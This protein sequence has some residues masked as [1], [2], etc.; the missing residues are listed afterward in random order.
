MRNQKLLILFAVLSFTVVLVVAGSI[1]FYIRSV[2]ADIFNTDDRAFAAEVVKAADINGGSIFLLKEQ[3]VIDRIQKEVSA[4]VIN[5]ERVFPDKV[6]IHA[7]K[8]F[9][10]A[11]TEMLDAGGTR[12]AVFD[13]NM[14]IMSIT[15][16]S[17][18]KPN[19]IQI[20]IDNNPTNT[21]FVKKI[22]AGAPSDTDKAL[23]GTLSGVFK[24][25]EQLGYDNVVTTFI[26]SVY[27]YSG[28]EY[29]CIK[30]KPRTGA[31]ST[32]IEITISTTADLL[33]QVRYGMSVYINY[34]IVK[35]EYAD[36]AG[37]IYVP[38]DFKSRTSY[39]PDPNDYK[40]NA[41]PRV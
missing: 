26:D 17:S 39:D 24:G 13:S 1:V 40:P 6:V 4:R 2:E 21:D 25:V 22:G 3:D 8:I 33:E 30:M 9:P 34:V 36:K 15:D 11:Y 28:G 29:V 31:G 32:G 14:N 27:V 5:I 35:P 38:A 41:S 12:Y 18:E 16:F 19:L 20:F 37:V 23:I 7:V 10:Y